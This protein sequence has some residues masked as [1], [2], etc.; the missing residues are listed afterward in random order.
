MHLEQS[1]LCLEKKIPLLIEKPIAINSTEALQIVNKSEKMD[2]PVLI[3]QHRRHNEIAKLSKN[4]YQ[5]ELSV[6]LDLFKL[7]VGSTS[8]IIILILLHGENKKEQARF[9]LI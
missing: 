6:K 8:L 2:T 1:L 7:L 9:M 4:Y 3:G 5:K